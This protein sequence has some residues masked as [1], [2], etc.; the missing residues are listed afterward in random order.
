MRSRFSSP[1]AKNPIMGNSPR[2]SRMISV[3]RRGAVNWF[4]PRAAQET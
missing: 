3:S 4:G 1:L 2:V